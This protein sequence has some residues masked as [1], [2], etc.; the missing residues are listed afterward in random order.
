MVQMA[1]SEHKVCRTGITFYGWQCSAR[2]AA[3]SVMYIRR[4]SPGHRY[5]GDALQRA[6][7]AKQGEVS[8]LYEQLL[9]ESVIVIWDACARESGV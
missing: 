8:H 6:M 7:S 4:L 1:V 5:L 2:E 9:P 3:S